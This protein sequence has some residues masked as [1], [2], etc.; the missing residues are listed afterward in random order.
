MEVFIGIILAV[1]LLYIIIY[2]I[3][4]RESPLKENVSFLKNTIN[5]VQSTIDLIPI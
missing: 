4:K 2:Y 5:E 1:F 3:K